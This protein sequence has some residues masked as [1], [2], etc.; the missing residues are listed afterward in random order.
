MCALKGLAAAPPM[1]WNSYDCYGVSVTE[2]EVLANA[3]VMA[4]RLRP[5][6][7]EYVVVDGEWYDPTRVGSAS[8]PKDP[9]RDA[10]D[11]YGRLIPAVE[12]FPSTTGGAGFAPLAAAVHSYGLKFGI[13]IMRGIPRRAV[14]ED[15]PVLGTPYTAREVALPERVC[16]WNGDMVGVNMEHPGGQAY[17]DSIVGLYAGW[18]VDFI[19]ADDIASP[20]YAD[21]VAGIARAI[22]RSGRPI[23]LSL[24]PG[25]SSPLAHAA[26]ARAHA[27]LVRISPDLWDSWSPPLE[28]FLTDLK[29]QFERCA[30]WAAHA[31]PGHWPDA[32]MLPVGRL[33]PRP[34]VG[35]DRP[36]GLSRDE[37]VAML[38]LWAICRSPLMIGGDLCSLDPWTEALLTNREVLAVNQTSRGGRELLRRGEV[39]VWGAETADGEGRYAA[40]FNLGDAPAAVELTPEDINVKALDV[41]HDLWRQSEAPCCHKRLAVTLPPHGAALYRV[42]GLR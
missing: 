30:A 11:A 7:W 4:E 39:V 38:T 20:Y 13:H 9:L 36:T 22:E 1:G 23:A 42:Q 8:P 17:Y 18:G 27:Q 37:Q 24:S 14:A 32:D 29:S 3:R 19:K 6:G 16:P 41:A 25:N 2:A 34:G 12:R 40:L 15:T 35:S 28:P 21:E 5:F 26:H 31:G 10:I 33:G